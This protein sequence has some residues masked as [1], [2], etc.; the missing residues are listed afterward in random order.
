[1]IRSCFVEYQE[2]FRKNHTYEVFKIS[3]RPDGTRNIN[4]YYIK[5]AVSIYLFTQQTL[6]KVLSRKA[7]KLT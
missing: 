4:A 1:M 7:N 5:T 6:T 2:L 3:M